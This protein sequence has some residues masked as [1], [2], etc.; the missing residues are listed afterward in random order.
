MPTVIDSAAWTI[1]VNPAS[2]GGRAARFAPR[3]A[4]ALERAR[5]R[6]A[7]SHS[8]A[9]GDAERQFS[10]AAL[11]G[12]RRLLA[13]GGDGSFN[14]LVN[15]LLASGIPSRDFLVAA[16]AGGTGN[17]WSRAMRVPDDADALAACMA[18]AAAR[19]ADIGIAD[20][21][22]GRRAAF[23]NVA[24]AGL[25]AEVI[26]HIPRR[27]PRAV[28][29]LFGLARALADYR[30]ARFEVVADGKRVQ[31]RFL[32]ALASIGPRC[33]GGM[34]LTPGAVV[35]DGWID[36]LTLDPLTLTGAFAR[37]PRLFDGR[38]AGDPAFHVIRCRTATIAADPPCGVELDG[39]L[40][41]TTPVTVTISPGALR[42][43]DCRAIAPEV[44]GSSRAK[45]ESSGG[46]RER[47]TP[48][49]PGRD[50]PVVSGKPPGSCRAS[51]NRDRAARTAPRS[52]PTPT[53]HAARGSPVASCRRG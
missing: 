50:G 45:S 28:A 29:Y 52:A 36:L 37:L 41:G 51:P 4:A 9:P 5:V 10:L 33:G 53:C 19:P 11:K 49:D 24:G 42:A 18:R 22:R 32:L 1:V 40:F 47:G 25:D 30:P 31:G 17:D 35:D 38:L 39:Q 27:G 43:L 8:A 26:A 44:A 46:V 13:V 12:V 16:A 23:H 34:R 48:P 7:M 6:F 14:E 20:D 3:L 15:G 21:G 2:G